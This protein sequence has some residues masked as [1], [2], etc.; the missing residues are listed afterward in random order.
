M[1]LCEVCQGDQF[2]VSDGVTYC[3][4]CGTESQ[5]HGQQ[6]VVDEET[7]GVFDTAIAGTIKSKRIKKKRSRSA[8]SMISEERK[9]YLRSFKVSFTT[10][11][12]LTYILKQWVEEVVALGAHESLRDTVS[13]L[14]FRYLA[15]TKRAF[16]PED[17]KIYHGYR[18]RS[19]YIYPQRKRVIDLSVV[20]RK[21]KAESTP[22]K[23]SR[24]RITDESDPDDNSAAAKRARARKRRKYLEGVSGAGMTTTPANHHSFLK[25]NSITWQ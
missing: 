18:D 12:A 14:W 1:V 11:E 21:L 13:Q 10:I 6:M 17:Q 3:Q 24:S 25:K 7:M 20:A 16:V 23:R 8:A 9:A 5:D 2:Y 19:T 4:N 22:K 15:A